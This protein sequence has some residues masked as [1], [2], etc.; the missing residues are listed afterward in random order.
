MPAP[1]YTRQLFADF[2]LLLRLFSRHA[3]S[4]H[5]PTATDSD[6][7]RSGRGFNLSGY[8]AA[9][10]NGTEDVAIVCLT[11]WN[12]VLFGSPHAQLEFMFPNL[13]YFP[14]VKIRLVWER[15]CSS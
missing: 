12:T 9:L 7:D 4:A 8:V 1:H 10:V 5:A 3:W 6:A 13:V 2:E 15:F 14:D 11:A